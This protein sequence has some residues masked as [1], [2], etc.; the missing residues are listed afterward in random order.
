MM[1]CLIIGVYGS[2]YEPLVLL[3]RTTDKD[4]GTVLDRVKK[5]VSRASPAI[6]SYIEKMD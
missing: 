6:G 2:T 5:E 1:T 3:V 4:D